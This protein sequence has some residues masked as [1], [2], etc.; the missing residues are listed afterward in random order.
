MKAL[1]TA[2]N[3]LLLASIVIVTGANALSL[4]DTIDNSTIKVNTTSSQTMKMVS[5]DANH[6]EYVL[7][8]STG[9]KNILVNKKNRV[10]GFNWSEKNPNLNGMLG[11]NNKYQKD[12]IKSMQTNKLLHRGLV[13]DTTNLHVTQYGLPG[14]VME[15]EMIAKDL[16]PSK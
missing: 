15:G 5:Q 8:S 9:E 7:K 4:G 1:N 2:K 10:Y 11:N 6:T 3:K 14:G 12:F 16:E 13:I